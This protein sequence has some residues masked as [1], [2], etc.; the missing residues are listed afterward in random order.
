MSAKSKKLAAVLSAAILFAA[1]AIITFASDWTEIEFIK[2]IWPGP[3]KAQ[4]DLAPYAPTPQQSFYQD[5]DEIGINVIYSGIKIP[6]KTQALDPTINCVGNNYH[7]PVVLDFPI[8]TVPPIP[9]HLNT[10]SKAVSIMG[11]VANMNY[12]ITEVDGH[13]MEFRIVEYPQ[14]HWVIYMNPY[15]NINNLTAGVAATSNN[16]DCE[17]DDGFISSLVT[18]QY[19]RDLG[20]R[21][22]ELYLKITAKIPEPGYTPNTSESVLKI[23]IWKEVEKHPEQTPIWYLYR[24]FYVD[25]PNAPADSFKLHY[26]EGVENFEHFWLIEGDQDY[27]MTDDMH[28]QIKFETLDVGVNVPIQIDSVMV[29]CDKGRQVSYNHY[30]DRSNSDYQDFVADVQANLDA[31]GTS[32]IILDYQAGERME[33]SMRRGSI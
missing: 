13:G 1:T 32:D 8:I 12:T 29:F 14:P 3:C 9:T 33:Q 5:L 2:H 24:Y 31:V 15:D 19:W 11:R 6:F 10:Y 4:W 23:K 27:L 25:H 17:G 16:Y 18:P 7:I 30:Y 21:D 26:V 20:Y 28:I 22:R